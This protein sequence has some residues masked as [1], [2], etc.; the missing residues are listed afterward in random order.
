MKIVASFFSS[1][2]K[3]ANCTQKFSFNKRR[4]CSSCSKIHL[5]LLF[6]QLCSIKVKKHPNSELSKKSFCVVCYMKQMQPSDALV[7]KKIYPADRL[8]HARASS[9]PKH[10]KLSSLLNIPSFSELPSNKMVS[11]I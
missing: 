7:E 9:D 6:C 2:S 10:R 5:G 11:F 3:C 8:L 4:V 1:S